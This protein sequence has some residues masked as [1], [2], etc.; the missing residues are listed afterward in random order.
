MILGEPEVSSALKYISLHIKRSPKNRGIIACFKNI[1][2]YKRICNAISKLIRVSYFFSN[3]D[4]F[5]ISQQS[6][7]AQVKVSGGRTAIGGGSTEGWPSL[8]DP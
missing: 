5:A 6:F 7:A 3:V 1:I 2:V 4:I 8:K